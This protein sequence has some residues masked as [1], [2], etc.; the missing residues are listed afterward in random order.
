MRQEVII[1]LQDSSRSFRYDLEVPTDVRVNKLTKDI[2]EAV[3]SY[4]SK[5]RH[6]QPLYSLYSERLKMVLPDDKTFAEIGVWTGDVIEI[7]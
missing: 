7:R 4:N 1:T 6:I 2:K 3:I 5:C